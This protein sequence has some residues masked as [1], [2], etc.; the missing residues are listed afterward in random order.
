M[1]EGTPYSSFA[2]PY[3]IRVDCFTC[4]DHLPAPYNIPALHLLTHTHIDHILG[5]SSKSFATRV[6]CSPDAKEMLLRHD[7]YLERTKND[8]ACSGAL[9]R[10]LLHTLPLNTPTEFELSSTET[11]TITHIDANHCP[12]AVIYC[13]LSGSMVPT[14]P[15]PLEHHS[16]LPEL[17]NLVSLFRPHRVVPDT[18]VPALGGLD[19]TTIKSIWWPEQPLLH[20]VLFL[21]SWNRQELPIPASSIPPPLTSPIQTRQLKTSLVISLNSKHR[22]PRERV[23]VDRVIDHLP[24]LRSEHGE[25]ALLL[26]WDNSVQDTTKGVRKTPIQAKCYAEVSDNSSDDDGSDAH[27]TT[28]HILFAGDD[29]SDAHATTAHILFAGDFDAP[30]SLKSWGSSSPSQRSYGEM[31]IVSAESL[32]PVQKQPISA[33]NAEADIQAPASESSVRTDYK[34]NACSSYP[35]LHLSQFPYT[36]IVI[37]PTPHSRPRETQGERN[38]N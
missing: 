36:G 33:T 8:A 10:D 16:P 22:R 14:M 4:T 23:V 13:L 34:Y 15:V 26:A 11:V 9:R 18:P 25:S 31:Q 35:I 19:W 20:S 17:L 2:L 6:A 38:L 12:G 3:P 7:V 21:T 30:M 27:A 24:R 5:V 29:G 32:G 28:A 1:P 37:H